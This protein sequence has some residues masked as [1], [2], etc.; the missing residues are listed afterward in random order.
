M[1]N[2]MIFNST[3]CRCLKEVLSHRINVTNNTDAK[4][5]RKHWSL[6]R[7]WTEVGCQTE[8]QVQHQQALLLA[9][10]W[11]SVWSHNDPETKPKCSAGASSPASFNLYEGCTLLSLSTWL[12]MCSGTSCRQNQQVRT[13]GN[14]L[15]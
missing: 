10:I 14:A 8:I 13:F 6:F 5:T 4:D 15:F 2:W 9:T 1:Q 11:A 7:K 12:C 3:N